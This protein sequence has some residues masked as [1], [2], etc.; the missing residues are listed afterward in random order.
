M[1]SSEFTCEKCGYRSEHLLMTC[2]ECNLSKADEQPPKPVQ[3]PVPQ[4]HITPTGMYLAPVS[5]VKSA[6]INIKVLQVFKIVC[7]VIAAIAIFMLVPFYIYPFAKGPDALGMYEMPKGRNERAPQKVSSAAINTGAVVI[8]VISAGFFMSF[9]VL[10]KK[11]EEMRDK[12]A[13][14]GHD[15][16]EEHLDSP[17][18]NKMFGG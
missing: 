4:S 5:D 3:P 12:F 8:I 11:E 9:M 7:G 10:R 18:A 15:A 17:D 6:A 13:A 2:P 14:E 16:P 1:F